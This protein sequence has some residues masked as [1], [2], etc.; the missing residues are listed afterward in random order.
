MPD[1][2]TVLR[3]LSQDDDFAAKYARAREAQGDTMDD[4]ILEVA[5]N[6]E[7]G[8]MAPDAARVVLGALQWRA[9]KL[10]PKK[11][12]ERQ[13]VEHEGSVDFVLR[14]PEPAKSAAEWLGNASSSGSPSPAPRPTS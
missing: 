10:K 5:D 11:Y 3:W 13:T 9:S 1:Q 8:T 6:V 7:A 2:S 14:A 4:R 12:G